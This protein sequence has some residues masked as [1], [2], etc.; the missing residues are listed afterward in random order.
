[1][2]QQRRGCIEFHN[3]SEIYHSGAEHTG[4]EFEGIDNGYS[5]ALV[6]FGHN[7]NDIRYVIVGG[8]V[9]NILI[10]RPGRGPKPNFSRWFVADR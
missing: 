2:S 8:A 1:M 4:C 9:V 3:L 10:D 5:C 6:V 7:F